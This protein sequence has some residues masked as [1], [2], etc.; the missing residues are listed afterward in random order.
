MRLKSSFLIDRVSSMFGEI[1]FFAP[2]PVGRK[3][4]KFG[5]LRYDSETNLWRLTVNRQYEITDVLMKLIQYH[6]EYSTDKYEPGTRVRFDTGQIA[7]S[8][9]V[10]DIQTDGSEGD[11]IDLYT[12]LVENVRHLRTSDD[13]FW[14]DGVLHSEIEAF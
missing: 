2:E 6:A 14:L 7:G 4:S 1:A 3:M 10:M 13:G 5:K 12:I 8:G 9:I 11:D